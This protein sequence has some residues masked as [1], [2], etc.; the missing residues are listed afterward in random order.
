[1]RK[2]QLPTYNVRLKAITVFP[3]T[4][5]VKIIGDYPEP[6]ISAPT[7]VKLRCGA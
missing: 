7:E 5:K 4:R 1:V 2:D 6:A 3:K